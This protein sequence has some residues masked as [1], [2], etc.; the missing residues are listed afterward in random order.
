M[1][2]GCRS[3]HE[4]ASLLGMASGAPTADEMRK[5]YKRAAKAWHPDRFARDVA[6]RLEAEEHFKLIQIAYR[7]LSEHNPDGWMPKTLFQS[8]YEPQVPSASTPLWATPFEGMHVE[9][10][11]SAGFKKTEEP[12]R[13]NP[14]VSDISQSEFFAGVPGCYPV[15]KF[16]PQADTI[17]HRYLGVTDFAYVA[18]DLSG[19]ERFDEFLM[20]TTKGILGRNHLQRVALLPYEE[21]GEL[22]I[23]GK[24][25]LSWWRRMTVSFS[26]DFVW[27]LEIYKRDGT[28]FHSLSEKANDEVKR[29]VYTFLQYRKMPN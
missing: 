3:C 6:K 14:F 29:A 16:P 20:M 4:N 9:G 25:S 1:S 13:K 12:V 21:M 7:E 5:A 19:G 26:E 15:Q 23:G 2:C 8:R 11:E 10:V 18:I 22:R 17:A 27:T 24:E 28:L